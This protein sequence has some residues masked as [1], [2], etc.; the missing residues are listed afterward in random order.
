MIEITYLEKDFDYEINALVS[1]FFPKQTFKQLEDGEEMLRLYLAFEKK[2]I[3][4]RLVFAEYR[5]EREIE[6][7]GEG[8]F[9]KKP[10]KTAHPYRTYYKNR[11]KRLLFEMLLDLP[12][13]ILPAAFEKRIP[14]W[15]TMTGVRPTKIPMGE[16]LAGRA[17]TEVFR[18]LREI[19][20]CS[21][22]NSR[23]CMEIAKKEAKL[24]Q[25]LDLEETY[26]LYIGIPFCPTTCLYCSFPSY[27]LEHFG[28]R[29]DRYL[30]ALFKEIRE[31]GSRCSRKKLTSVYIGGGTPTA[32]S[33]EQ[34]DRLLSHIRKYFPASGDCEFTV[35]AG[36]PDSITREK[37]FVLRKYGIDR[38][39]VNPQTMQQKTLDLIGRKHTVED[40]KNAFY[41]AREA[42][43]A[44]INMDLIVGLPEESLEDFKN[45][46]SE[47]E[48][49]LPDSITVHSLVIKRASKLREILE[50]RKSTGAYAQLPES[51]K[52]IMKAEER[53]SLAEQMLFYAKEELGK[54]KYF[55][56]YMY[57]QK[58]SAGH[59]G[60][61]GQE[62]IGFAREG[63]ECLYNILIMEEM[64][65][66]LALG[67]GAS[68]KC[69]RTIEEEKAGAF[70][71]KGVV[72]RIE[73]VKSIDDYINRVDEMIERKQHLWH[74]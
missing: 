32:L 6:V 3:F 5:K 21:E 27:P 8:D 54:K 66:I 62:N 74:S 30:E 16:L 14:A 59:A 29:A 52:K 46:L 7:S 48:E 25:G 19:Y 35:E 33:A 56:Y 37:L 23:L 11:L 42:G 1:S 73:N 58:N 22:E 61:N 47:V 45:T 41:L 53:M 65:S 17:E 63:K 70:R 50:E 55:P 49:L 13:E 28:D 18:D 12:E 40:T 69:Y 64:Q 4:I 15:G 24:L 67:A 34:L 31:S 2:R 9:H 39:S 60:S 26:S 20:C 57:R 10:D 36:R 71:G 51:G 43:F 72:S 38:I 68:T 44:N